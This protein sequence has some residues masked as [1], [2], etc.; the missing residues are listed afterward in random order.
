MCTHPAIHVRD[1]QDGT[2]T[3]RQMNVA[4]TVPLTF[5]AN[6]YLTAAE[7][8]LANR[9]PALEFR[10]VGFSANSVEAIYHFNEAVSA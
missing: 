6:H 1:N 4:E 9:W 2:M 5:R 3:A 8:Y 10:K 7:R